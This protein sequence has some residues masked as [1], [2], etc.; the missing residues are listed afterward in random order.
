MDKEEVI[1]DLDKEEK[2]IQMYESI[3]NGMTVLQESFIK[4]ERQMDHL[5]VKVDKQDKS[6]VDFQKKLEL[7]TLYIDSNNKRD[8]DIDKFTCDIV[9]L[10]K[11][12][13]YMF[14]KFYNKIQYLENFIVKQ[15]KII[16]DR[17]K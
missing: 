4:L 8:L 15:N 11:D 7:L 17:E 1:E 3:F 9:D 13:N 16:S 5:I 2:I 6:Y 10:K 12:V 14:S